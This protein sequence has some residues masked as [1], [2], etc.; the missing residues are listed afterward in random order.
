MTSIVL[1]SLG[2]E[3]TRN[4]ITRINSPQHISHTLRTQPRE[5]SQH[6]Y[7]HSGTARVLVT[8]G[9]VLGESIIFGNLVTILNQQRNSEQFR[10]DANFYSLIFALHMSDVCT[11]ISQDGTQCKISL[12]L[13]VPQLQVFYFSTRL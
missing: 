11:Y 5:F 6:S 3:A 2:A 1:F 12:R 10:S 9:L 4:V 8:G 7:N 13:L